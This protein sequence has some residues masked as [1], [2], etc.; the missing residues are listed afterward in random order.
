MKVLAIPFKDSL[1]T[2]GIALLFSSLLFFCIPLLLPAAADSYLAFFFLHF[3]FAVGYLITLRVQRRSKLAEHRRQYT[4]LLLILLLISAYALNRELVVFATSPVWFCVLL[5]VLCSNYGISIFFDKLPQWAKGCIAF[6]LGISAVAFVYLTIYLAPLYIFG[7]VAL[8]ALGI[9]IHTFVPLLFSVYTFFLVNDLAARGRN[10]WRF[11]WVG[12]ATVV[13]VVAVYST[14]WQQN[15]KKINKAY[16]A[17]ISEGGND[18]P[19]WIGIA[20]HID[21]NAVIEKILKT[22]LVYLTPRWNENIFWNM[23]GRTFGETQQVH[24]PLVVLATLFSSRL[25][26]NDDDKINIL[27]SMFKGRHQTEERLW[28][29]KDL[30]TENVISTIRLWPENHLAYTEKAVTVFNNAGTSWVRQQEAIYTFHLPEGGVVTSL[31]LWVAGKEEKG[32]LTTKEKADSAYK[33]IVGVESR[34][35][36]VVHWKEG[37]RVTVRVF[38]VVS[39]S[40]RVF[41]IGI[42]APLRKSGDKLVYDNI[43]FDGPDA[44]AAEEEVKLTLSKTAQPGPQPASFSTVNGRIF[45]RAGAYEPAWSFSVAD[46]GVAPQVFHFNGYNYYLKTYVPQRAP[47]QLTDIYAD[48]NSAWTEADFETVWQTAQHKKVWVYDNDLIQLTEE[49]RHGLF[50]KLVQNRFSL[51]PLFSIPNV[52]TAMLVSKSG[53]TA[54]DLSD[55]DGSPF[56]KDLKRYSNQKKKLMLFTIGDPLSPYLSSLKEFRFFLYEHGDLKKLAQ[57]VSSGQFAADAENETEVVVHSAG[58]SILKQK[59]EGVSNA[60]D[61]LMRLFAYNHI[62]QQAGQQGLD[63]FSDSSELVQTAKEA[64]V[65]SPV[66]SLVVLETQE[67]YNRFG[68]KD[69]EANLKN[70]SLKSKGAVPE[71]HEWVLLI[72]GAAVA[73]ILLLKSKF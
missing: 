33:T 46:E 9:S 38:P 12:V 58:I 45:T 18:V 22:G 1:F 37:N 47:V 53:S 44:S 7:A 10:T 3:A 11:F 30:R 35:P 23:P 27:K 28:T 15:T 29:G 4:F 17:A 26:L 66:S 48:V 25:Y 69:S 71:P 67:D 54:P 32:L 13:V 56:L 49:N 73:A 36:S 16:T 20:Q 21:D 6:L 51:F 65:V 62:M 40:N 34:D 64:Y 68:I 50:K 55:L 2:T 63:H 19:T 72:L 41:K 60:P 8:L 39:N 42:T 14:V 52:E 70:A 61:H 5:V 57:L 59:G 24:D 43:A 31:S